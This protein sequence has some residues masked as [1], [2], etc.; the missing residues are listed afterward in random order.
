[1]INSIPKKMHFYWGMQELS[2]LQYLTVVSFHRTNPDW[3]IILHYP[4][5]PSAEITW[6]SVEHKAGL[7]GVRNFTKELFALPYLTLREVDFADL[8]CEFGPTG[9]SK[10]APCRF[11]RKHPQEECP[12]LNLTDNSSEVHKSDYLR[13]DILSTEGGFWSDMD[14]L[15]SS[16]LESFFLSSNPEQDTVLCR[17]NDLPLRMPDDADAEGENYPIVY[18]GFMGASENNSNFQLLKSS[19]HNFFNPD[20]YQSIGSYLYRQ[21]YYDLD[22]DSIFYYHPL[23]TYPF[24]WE[25]SDL[26][27]FFFEPVHHLNYRNEK[28]FMVDRDLIGVHW[29]NGNPLSSIFTRYFLPENQFEFNHTALGIIMQKVFA[30]DENYFSNSLL[31]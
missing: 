31:Q 26:Q 12:L 11:N 30:T 7:V 1:M 2:Y 25:K 23:V 13:L 29:C 5:F 16:P 24:G 15:F 4:K 18:I 14:I 17:E 10:V 21:L 9:H 6:N 19:A 3:E 8:K 28:V 27:R 20:V 22:E